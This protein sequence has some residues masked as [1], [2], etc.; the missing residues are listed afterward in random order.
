MSIASVILSVGEVISDSRLVPISDTTGTRRILPGVKEALIEK[1]DEFY[2]NDS[3][4]NLPD[5]M[6]TNNKYLT[7]LVLSDDH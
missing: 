3:I 7:V 4:Q 2:W 1:S 5:T 6:P